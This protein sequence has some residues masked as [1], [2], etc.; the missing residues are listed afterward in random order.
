M[1]IY[2]DDTIYNIPAPVNH[3]S[4]KDE[5]SEYESDSDTSIY[6]LDR[7]TLDLRIDLASKAQKTFCN[8]K[9][10]GMSLTF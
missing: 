8:I 3:S 2:W 7:D 4:D 10:Q 5:D 6:Q 1:E 9:G